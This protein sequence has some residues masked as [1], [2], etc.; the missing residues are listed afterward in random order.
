MDGSNL[1]T[2]V[3][4]LSDVSLALLLSLIARGHCILTTS[5]PEEADALAD[6]VVS[7]AT[8]IFALPP[9]IVQ[10][11]ADMTLETFVSALLTSPSPARTPPISHLGQQDCYFSTAGPSHSHIAPLVLLRDLDAASETVQAQVLELM[12]SRAIQTRR[13]PLHAPEPFLVVAQLVQA[14]ARPTLLAP[15]LEQF[16]LSHP[17]APAADD[18]ASTA[19]QHSVIHRPA[20]AV[21]RPPHAPNAHAPLPPAALTHLRAL[22]DAVT[23]SG[24]L[25]RYVHDIAVHL[26]LHRGVRGGGVS[27]RAT[28]DFK[29]LVRGLAALHGLDF[30][31]PALVQLAVFKVYAH[32][33][34][35]VR[36]VEEERSVLWGSDERVVGEFV[37]DVEVEGVIEDVL[38]AVRAPL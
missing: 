12:R 36:R 27:A 6:E 18:A 22:A 13:G 17:K 25:Q 16:F 5:T 20:S 35:L 7:I 26:R 3:R 31:T 30:V 24:E 1:A 21:P 33:I 34:R 32:R 23:M 15:L 4:Q 19:S 11:T 28:R 9:A 10:C 14:G 8:D 37:K 38:A 2:L 29:T